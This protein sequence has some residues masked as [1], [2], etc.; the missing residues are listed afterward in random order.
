MDLVT[1]FLL[2][3][4]SIVFLINIATLGYIIAVNGNAFGDNFFCSVYFILCF[5]INFAIW[6]CVIAVN[7]K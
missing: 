1:F 2:C 7:G 6:D 3:I 5:L 4:F